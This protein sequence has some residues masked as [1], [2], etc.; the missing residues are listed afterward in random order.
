MART[1]GL[2]YISH[3]LID[4]MLTMP[5]YHQSLIYPWLTSLQKPSDD[6][7]SALLSLFCSSMA[8]CTVSTPL[9]ACYLHI[10]ISCLQ[11]ANDIIV[12][13]NSP[14]DPHASIDAALTFWKRMGLV[15]SSGKTS[16]ACFPHMMTVALDL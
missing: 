3:E 5:D 4:V 6:T 12:V 14:C 11:Y 10:R 2:D 9:T 7:P 16:V 8:S 1:T 13:A 15:F